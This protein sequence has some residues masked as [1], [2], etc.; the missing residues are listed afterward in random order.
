MGLHCLHSGYFMCSHWKLHVDHLKQ[1]SGICV[2]CVMKVCSC[3]YY[4]VL[5]LFPVTFDYF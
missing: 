1:D 3:L 4:I 5:K 2:I